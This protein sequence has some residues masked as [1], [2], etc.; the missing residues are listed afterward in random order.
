M[1]GASIYIVP[2]MIQRNVPGI[3]PYVLPAF[4]FAAIPAVL[5]AL[6]YAMLS[7]AMP[8]AG[9]SYIF[10]SRGLH[11]YL[12]FV[13]SFA[14]WFGLSIAIGVISYV[15]PTFFRDIAATLGWQDVA[16]ALDAGW[17]RV[18]FALALL[19]G[20]TGVNMR[21][22]S[23]YER[24]LIP[25]MI[26]M[27][28]LGLIVIIAGF[29]LDHHDFT[30][31]LP[32]MEGRNLDIASAAVFNIDTFLAAAAVLFSGFIGFDAV[33]QAGGE[34]K[35]PEKLL[36]R[37][38]LLAILAVGTFYFLF[39]SA[40]YH[41]V[42]WQYVA[43]AAAQGDISAPGL[44]RFLLPPFWTILIM[45]GAA[46]ALL[47]DLPAMLLSV[48]RL[49]FAW[50]A[51]GVFPK[52]M[53]AVH[54]GS[55]TPR[56]ALVFSASMATTGILGSHFAGDFFLGVD[57]MVT[58]MLVN[59]LLMCLTVWTL[60]AINPALAN[61]MGVIR[62]RSLQ[63]LLAA[64]GIVFLTGFLLIHVWKDLRNPAQA[65]YFHATPVWLLV[66]TLG[67]GIYFWKIRA[68]KKKGTDI[69]AGFKQ[70]PEG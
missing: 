33:A 12:G 36:P 66:M 63:R 24:T 57:I 3:G 4:M 61:G 44:F 10:A 55:R 62:N 30:R 37:A 59:F 68:L 48:S 23:F 65:W 52:R 18:A 27:F 40:V 28:A 46:V 21:G 43:E 51:D 53:A 42:P 14:Q 8:R 17:G 2:F 56:R 6:A 47:N 64:L 49:V 35:N 58:S 29:S 25:L 16:A 67:S 9:G 19:W 34:A 20:F 69:A 60:P 45:T 70:L 38:I 31:G 1:L 26:L 7:S 13:A 15:L 32:A 39:T 11:P 50:S 41:A 22:L 54:S 5:A